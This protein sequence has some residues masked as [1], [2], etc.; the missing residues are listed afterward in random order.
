M[1]LYTFLLLLLLLSCK[2]INNDFKKESKLT[3]AKWLLGRWQNN[4]LESIVTETWKEENDSVFAGESYIVQVKDT[5]FHELIKLHETNGELFYTVSIK[6]NSEE[7]PVSFKL[8]KA[9]NSLLIFENPEHDFPNKISYAKISEDSIYAEISGL[10]RGQMAK[11]G[12]PFKRQ[13]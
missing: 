2:N 1:K 8:T 11:E 10:I 5:I 9:T 12:F 3:S 4:K 6:N 13:R 7:I